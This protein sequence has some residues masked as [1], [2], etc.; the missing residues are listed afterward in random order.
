[1]ALQ[2]L[3]DQANAQNRCMTTGKPHYALNYSN[4]DPVHF[5]GVRVDADPC[6]ESPPPRA[7]GEVQG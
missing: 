3:R 2:A 4:G 7:T 6:F 1:M 5:V